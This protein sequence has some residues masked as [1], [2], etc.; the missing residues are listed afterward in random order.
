AK[1]RLRL[2]Q[3]LEQEPPVPR[4]TP[5]VT[6]MTKR[7]KVARVLRNV[8]PNGLRIEEIVEEL[9]RS[10]SEHIDK[11]SLSSTLNRLKNEEYIVKGRANRWYWLQ[12]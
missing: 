3:E 4:R 7:E 9:N 10:Y 8:A 2:L 6:T 5:A 12:K 11:P 1:V